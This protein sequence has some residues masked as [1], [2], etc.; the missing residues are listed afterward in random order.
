MLII[1]SQGKYKP[2]PLRESWLFGS[3]KAEKVG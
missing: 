2:S 3:Y 1:K